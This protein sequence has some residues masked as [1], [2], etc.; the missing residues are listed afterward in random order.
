M[1]ERFYRIWRRASWVEPALALAIVAG[2]SYTAWF[3]IDAGFLPQP[4]FY[5]ISDTWMDWFNTAYWGHDLGTYDS[6][7]SVYP[8]LTFLLLDM[9]TV[10]RCYSDAYGYSSRACDWFGIVAVHGVFILNIFLIAKAY[11]ANDRSTALPRTIAAACGFPALVAL[12]RG[13]SLLM[14]YTFFI[15]AHSTILRSARLRWIAA[16]MSVN[17]K[18]YILVS[19]LPLV[20]RRRWLWV[21]GVLIATVSIYLLSWGLLGRGSPFELLENIGDFSGAAGG[22]ALQDIWYAATYSSVAALLDGDGYP[23]SSVIGSWRVETGLLAIS[24]S[25]FVVQWTI[26][27]ALVATWLRPEAVKPVRL[28]NLGLSLLLITSEA[29]G[30]SQIFFVF[31]TLFE[32]WKGFGRRFAIVAAYVSCIPADIFIDPLIFWLRPGFNDGPPS[33]YEFWITAGPFVRP[34]IH[35]SMPFALALV[36]LREVGIDV[37]RQRWRQ[38]WRFRRD[39]PLLL[40]PTGDYQ[41]PI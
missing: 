26:I 39:A 9:L 13:N 15:L 36:T 4:F 29:S 10:G 12:E 33:F 32:P 27:A 23:I 5:D 16:G 40:G 41:Q 7:G 19:F 11:L 31:L 37:W 22:F 2:I 30:Y 34:G 1:K 6:W 24:W 28:A 38:R 35:L 3:L 14:C 21:E 25:L 17:L 18:I 8:P 20:L